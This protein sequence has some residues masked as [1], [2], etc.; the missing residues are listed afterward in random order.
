MR[1]NCML[2]FVVVSLL[3][4]ASSELAHAGPIT[5]VSRSESGLKSVTTVAISETG[6]GATGSV[7]TH[8]DF[9]PAKDIPLDPTKPDTFNKV[10]GTTVTK[11]H[12]Y[13][14][15]ELHG[16]TGQ[17]DYEF[18]ISKNNSKSVK[19]TGTVTG[20]IDPGNAKP[21]QTVAMSG[22]I[23][24]PFVFSDSDPNANFG[25]MPDGLDYSFS[26]LQGTSFPDMFTGDVDSEGAFAGGTSMTFRGRL[27][28][29]ATPDPELFWNSNSSLFDLY[30]LFLTS[31]TAHNVQAQLVF[32]SAG[33]AF[34]DLQFLNSMGL[35]FDPTDHGA[36]DAI[37]NAIAAAFSGG[38]LLADLSDLFTVRFTPR[39]SVT[40]FTVGSENSVSL[41]GPEPSV[42]AVPEPATLLL[43]GSGLAGGSA[44]RRRR[45]LSHQE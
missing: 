22:T 26:L 40:A 39:S 42:S 7:R 21:P 15:G 11:S 18:L 3:L 27:A 30:T 44:L 45:R 8:F 36:I 33:N 24:D 25:F 35:S 9:H 1:I 14:D 31:D 16:T 32:G 37:E 13:G 2:R 29:G 43:L 28:P 19:M 20:T 5:I 23:K 4:A 12:P 10:I 6:K 34:F 38:A 17:A 41:A